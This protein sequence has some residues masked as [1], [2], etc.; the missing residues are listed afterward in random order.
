[1]VLCPS[2]I[3]SFLLDD[4]STNEV[5]PYPEFV[6]PGRSALERLDI[7]TS[8]DDTDWSLH[9]NISKWGYEWT[10]GNWHNITQ[11]KR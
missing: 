8:H 4:V 7:S 6:I 2:L 1:M 10:N 9:F 3:V 5:C 11:K